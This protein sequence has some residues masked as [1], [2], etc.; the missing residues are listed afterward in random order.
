MPNSIEE[1]LYRLEAANV[2]L[3]C[4]LAAVFATALTLGVLGL[5]S[6]NARS[7]EPLDVQALN[8]VDGK[9]KV[10]A[11]LVMTDDGPRLKFLDADGKTRA[12]LGHSDRTGP[13]LALL[14]ADEQERAKLATIGDR[15]LLELSGAPNVLG[16]ALGAA[17]SASGMM[18]FD[19][20]KRV[21]ASVEHTPKGSGLYLSDGDGKARVTLR[22]KD[23]EAG[24]VIR[25]QSGQSRL[26]LQQSGAGS[27]IVVFDKEKDPRIVLAEASSECVLSLLAPGQEL[28]V[29]FGVSSGETIGA[30]LDKGEKVVWRMPPG[31]ADGAKVPLILKQSRVDERRPGSPE[32]LDLGPGSLKLGDK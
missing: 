29:E 14:G 2:R 19:E 30:V 15:A 24:L 21:R 17:P 28:R 4:I 5:S 32:K 18:L 25:D 22:E 10:R 13:V 16:V 6:R 1:R 3:R 23:I 12:S 27:S 20:H 31:A 9:G 26:A 11:A 7:P 8:L